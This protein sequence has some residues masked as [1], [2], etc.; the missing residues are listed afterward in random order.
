MGA[1]AGREYST[2]AV[3]LYTVVDSVVRRGF[4]IPNDTLGKKTKRI[5]SLATAL[6]QAESG[7]EVA[8][9]LQSYAAPVQSYRGKRGAKG[10]YL[11][12]NAYLGAGGGS[13]SAGGDRAGYIGVAAPIG[14]EAGLSLGSGFSL[15]VL[16]QVLDLGAL[17]SFRMTADDDALESE[18][19]VGF[20]QVFSPG[21]YLVLGFPRLPLA[22]GFGF[23]LAPSL[24]KLSAD[25][26]TT[27]NAKRVAVFASIDMPLLR[28]K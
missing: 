2:A 7:E 1:L 28:V 18:P 4:K 19:E 8:A 12:I 23:N 14:V 15:G 17:A 27:R 11:A 5:L 9:V 13:E 16:G 22:L 25:P 20:A 24:R 10:G 21:G 26:E 6:A 3:A